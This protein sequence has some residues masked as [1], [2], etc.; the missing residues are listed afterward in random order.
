MDALRRV[1][2]FT[3]TALLLPACGGEPQGAVPPEFTM[4]SPGNAAIGVDGTPAF[5]WSALNGATGY[6]LQVATEDTFSSPIVNETNLTSTSFSPAV[7]LNPGTVFFWR[8]FAV[9]PAGTVAA[10][11]S[12]FTFTTVAP[13]PGGFTMTAPADEA[14]G[15][16]TSPTFTWSSSLGAASYRLQVSTES[17]FGSLALDLPN[18][19]TTSA[20]SSVA[21]APSTMYF[22]R[23]L[24]VS[25]ATVTATDA[26]FTFTTQAAPP[27]VVTAPGSFTLLTPASGAGGVTVLPTFSWQSSSGA[28]LYRLEVALD[29]T[30]VNTVLD[31]E[32][33]TSTSVTPTTSLIPLTTYYWRVT[34]T[35]SGGSTVASPAPL[36]FI[37]G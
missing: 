7:V 12:P 6:T 9:G 28:T 19:D 11:G 17:G 4:N 29:P 21:L 24:A 25:T 5:S 23:V 35:N 8:V 31:L 32:G 13:I 34:A 30:F 3:G 22:W 18:L 15:V 37:T 1:A 14:L 33:L 16:S 26:P 27:P 36:S 10:D 20:L 2:L